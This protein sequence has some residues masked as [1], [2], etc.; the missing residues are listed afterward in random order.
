VSS[1]DTGCD[2]YADWWEVLDEEGQLL[3]RRV[4]L[5][6]HVGEQ[7]F[8]RSG[9][10]VSVGTEQIVW[11]R[12]HMNSRGYGRVAFR[13]SVQDGFVAFELAA[14]LGPCD[15]SLLGDPT[16]AASWRGR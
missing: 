14:E 15:F 9:G 12:A 13:G 7:P 16:A 4:L 6:S 10:S 8:A 3:Y 1:P 2:Q 11:V 5:H